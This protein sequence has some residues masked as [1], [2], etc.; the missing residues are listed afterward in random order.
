[1]IAIS[2]HSG[3]GSRTN[4][5]CE[6]RFECQTGGRGWRTKLESMRVDNGIHIDLLSYINGPLGDFPSFPLPSPLTSFLVY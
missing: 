1:M 4:W 5:C 2:S 3:V 6:G